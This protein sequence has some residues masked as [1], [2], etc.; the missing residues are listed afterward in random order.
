MRI[1]T[2][3]FVLHTGGQIK[4]ICIYIGPFL[5]SRF[6]YLPFRNIKTSP[7]LFFPKFKFNPRYYY[8]C[9]AY[10]VMP[11]TTVTRRF[12]AC[13]FCS[14]SLH[15]NFTV[16][17]FILCPLSLPHSP[18]SPVALPLPRVKYTYIR[19]RYIRLSLLSSPFPFTRD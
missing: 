18:P 3:K 10:N 8:I 9:G 7:F 16:R 6:L 12:R 1:N 13:V 5:F 17:P 2:A 15:Q 19:A 4:T 14:L 11:S